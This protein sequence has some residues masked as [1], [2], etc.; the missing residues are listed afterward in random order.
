MPS[1]FG[2]HEKVKMQL[3]GE[4]APTTDSGSL[5]LVKRV[6]SQAASPPLADAVVAGSDISVTFETLFSR[7]ANTTEPLRMPDHLNA[8]LSEFE[9]R[10]ASWAALCVDLVN[11]PASAVQN[12]VSRHPSRLN[13]S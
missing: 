2:F 13:S 4:L 10:H 6:K 8:S 1:R 7:L 12:A 11:A 5:K 3:S 9:A